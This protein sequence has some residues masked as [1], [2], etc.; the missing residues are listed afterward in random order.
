MRRKFNI[1]ILEG[2]GATEAAPV[3]AAN[4]LE[5]NKPGTVGMLME[6][7]EYELIPVEG[8]EDGGRMRV[9]GPNVM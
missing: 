9:R 3:I 2:Y 8:I 6:G 1:E 4:K 7:M 5:A